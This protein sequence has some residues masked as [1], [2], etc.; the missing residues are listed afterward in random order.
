MT[1]C[2]QTPAKTSTLSSVYP[3]SNLWVVSEVN[4][5]TNDSVRTGGTIRPHY[6]AVELMK[7]SREERRRIL[8]EAADLAV[9]EYA[10]NPV[11][12]AFDA[13]GADDLYDE[14]S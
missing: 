3:Q 7:L 2:W 9:A 13:F 11:L 14:T 8:E 6:T 12:T 5:M 4:V 10:S 1:I